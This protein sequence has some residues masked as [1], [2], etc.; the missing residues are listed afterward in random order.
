MP[1]GSD[2]TTVLNNN[3]WSYN[4]DNISINSSV[5]NSNTSCYMNLC[6]ERINNK[7]NESLVLGYWINTD[8]SDKAWV[9]NN[10]EFKKVSKKENGYGVRPIIIVKK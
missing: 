1:R 7:K 4:S 9:I 8:L 6:T 3:T 5:L 10:N 2:I